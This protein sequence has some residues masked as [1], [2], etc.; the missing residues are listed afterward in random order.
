MAP[1][2]STKALLDLSLDQLTKLLREQHS[3]DEGFNIEVADMDD[4]SS[5]EREAL[6]QK[7]Q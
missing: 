1:I 7:L 2:T 3:G 6:A 4:L 5:Q